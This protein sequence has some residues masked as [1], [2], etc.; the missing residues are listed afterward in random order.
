MIDQD[1]LGAYADWL[2]TQ[3]H[4][5]SEMIKPM[6]ERVENYRMVPKVVRDLVGGTMKR[7]LATS[8]LSVLLLAG[9]SMIPHRIQ[10]RSPQQWSTAIHS[11]PPRASRI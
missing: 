5:H 2:H 11:S 3:D 7:V 8:M 4:P 1:T 9:C 10:R 6:E